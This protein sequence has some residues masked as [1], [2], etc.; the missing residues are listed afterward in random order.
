MD[1]CYNIEDTTTCTYC[2]QPIYINRESF[3][4][5]LNATEFHNDCYG[6]Y[7]ALIYDRYQEV[8]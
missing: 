7:I 1:K 4:K 2:G 5:D 8:V 6:K 3:V